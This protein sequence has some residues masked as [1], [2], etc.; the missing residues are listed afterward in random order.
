MNC[1]DE[2]TEPAAAGKKRVCIYLASADELFQQTEDFLQ[3]QL[4]VIELINNSDGW[5]Y[6]RMYMDRKGESTAF[7]DMLRDCSAGKIDIIVTRSI[8][9]FAGSIRDTLQTA[10]MLA[11]YDPPVEILFIEQ[12]IFTSDQDKLQPFLERYGIGKMNQD[13]CERVRE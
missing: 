3:K 13:N 8:W 7:A 2:D 4:V 11:S 1:I 9:V 10:L 5:V 6:E 12:A